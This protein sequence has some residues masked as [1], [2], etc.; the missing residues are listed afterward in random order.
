MKMNIHLTKNSQLVKNMDDFINK[1]L[2]INCWDIHNAYVDFIGEKYCFTVTMKSKKDNEIF[3]EKT[4]SYITVKKNGFI[5][6]KIDAKYSYIQVLFYVPPFNFEDTNLYYSFNRIT[7]LNLKQIMFDKNLPTIIVKSYI[8]D[9]K[10]A[11]QLYNI[12]QQTI[13]NKKELNGEI[14]WNPYNGSKYLEMIQNPDF[15]SRWNLF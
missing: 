10:L 5:R 7:E 15:K 2:D 6:G 9:K 11:I 13:E 8:P 12:E 3:D 4:N 1:N 14:E